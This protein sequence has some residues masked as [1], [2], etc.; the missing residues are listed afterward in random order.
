MT[1]EA[2]RGC[3]GP[4]PSSATHQGLILGAQHPPTIFSAVTLTTRCR[5]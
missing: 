3:L 1:G 2:P 5:Y 4:D